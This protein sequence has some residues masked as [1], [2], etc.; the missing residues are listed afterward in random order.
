MYEA[1]L[2]WGV[3]VCGVYECAGVGCVQVGGGYTCGCGGYR[4][5]DICMRLC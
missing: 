2:M 3:W 4:Y 5:V 1:M